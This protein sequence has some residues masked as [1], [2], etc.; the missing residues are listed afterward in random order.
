MRRSRPFVGLA[1]LLLI[2]GVGV[3]AS[4]AQQTESRQG[5]RRTEGLAAWEQ[6]RSVLV[7]PRCINCHTAVDYP[8]QGDAR[9]RHFANV[10][11]G[12]D[13]HGVPGLQ[14]ATCHQESN[15][16]STGVPG[17]HNWHLAPL[18]MAWQD[19]NDEPLSSAAIC[20]AVTDRRKN[21][22]MDG[23]ALLKHNAE[24]TLVR[25]AWEPGRDI[26]GV[27]RTLP[28]MSRAEFAEATRRWVDAGMPCPE[29]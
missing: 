22:N 2:V 29:R 9:R 19:R 28:P 24:D 16:D 26:H 7:H 17:S 3:F 11:R 5:S 14:C 10:V 20:R 23:R 8:H 13:G 1:L 6:V 27:S 4:S 15:A 21:H 12:P 25:W 18:S